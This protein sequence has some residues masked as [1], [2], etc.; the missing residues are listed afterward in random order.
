ME[1]TEE[2]LTQHMP[3]VRKKSDGSGLYEI[4]SLSGG[5][6]ATVGRAGITRLKDSILMYGLKLTPK[7]ESGEGTKNN[8]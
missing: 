6:I 8:T 2:Y 1:K 4:Y 7:E 5:L 3:R